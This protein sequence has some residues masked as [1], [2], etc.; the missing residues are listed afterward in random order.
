MRKPAPSKIL[1]LQGPD[2][3]FLR[4]PRP[5]LK[6]YLRTLNKLLERAST[7]AKEYDR[8]VASLPACMNETG[9][10]QNVLSSVQAR[11]R[12]RRLNWLRLTTQW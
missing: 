3:D 4:Q 7:E 12:G 8:E 5:S 2:C 11:D 6:Q 1:L 9:A 10:A